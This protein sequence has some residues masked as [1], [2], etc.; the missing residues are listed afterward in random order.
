MKTPFSQTGLTLIEVLVALVIV[1]IAFGALLQSTRSTIL[2]YQHVREKI[3]ARMVATNVL[4]MRELR[5]LFI[6]V[7]RSQQGRETFFDQNW[8]WNVMETTT[9]QE[10]IH[11]IHVDVRAT[12]STD[13]PVID[14]LDGFVY[15]GR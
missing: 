1:S 8:Y 9:Q 6:Q 3:A 2:A 12:E 13:A 10:F 7:G 15:A 4:T 11:R 14:Q 5:L